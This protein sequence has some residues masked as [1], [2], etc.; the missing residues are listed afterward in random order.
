[1]FLILPVQEN[2]Y[3]RITREVCTTQNNASQRQEN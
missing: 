1:M 3:N 2:S